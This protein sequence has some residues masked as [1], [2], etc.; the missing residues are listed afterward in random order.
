[1]PWWLLDNTVIAA[2][3]A[4]IVAL[5]CRVRRVPPVVRHALW[6]VV[7]IKL[8]APPLFP[9]PIKIPVQW[10]LLSERLAAT[11][12]ERADR[13]SGILPLQTSS[14]D[15]IGKAVLRD[16]RD[17]AGCRVDD[18]GTLQSLE[19]QPEPPVLPEARDRYSIIA[20]RAGSPIN[21][22]E[23]LN[24][25][26]DDHIA[27]V[28]APQNID[29][30][31]NA[32]DPSPPPASPGATL[33]RP[34]SAATFV[35]AGFLGATC[36]VIGV[37][38]LRLVNLRRL[39]TRARQAPGDFVSIV[40][41]LAVNVGVTAPQV[42]F[43]ADI[44][45]PLVC[46]F[47]LPVLVWPASRLASLRDN[48]LRAVI[49]H[50]LAHL[51]R[52]D[53]LVGWLELVAGCLWWW[54]PLFWYVQHQLRETAELACDAWVMALIPEG[55]RDYAR[56][57][58][59]LAELDFR[60]CRAALALGV[61]EGSKNLFERRLVMIM[62]TRVR[63]RMGIFG[64]L[65]TG[66]LA[67]A[68]LPGCTAG[69]AGDEP[70]VAAE[71]A[72]ATIDTEPADHRF[73]PVSEPP[74][75]RGP[76]LIAANQDPLD[77]VDG[78]LSSAVEDSLDDDVAEVPIEPPVALPTILPVPDDSFASDSGY[79]VGPGDTATTGKPSNDDRLKR[80]ED[81]F[82][83]L[84]NELRDAKNPTSRKSAPPAFDAQNVPSS[85]AQK[86]T[87]P[88]PSKPVKPVPAAGLGPIH[89]TKAPHRDA[90]VETVALTRA[91][92]KFPAD[93]A[94]ALKAF[95]EFLAAHLS[96]EVEVRFKDGA[97]QVTATSEDQAVIAQFIRLLQ[98]RGSAEPKPSLKRDDR[99]D[100]SATPES[101]PFGEPADDQFKPARRE[102]RREPLAPADESVPS[103]RGPRVGF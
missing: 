29:A 33:S 10:R 25:G 79:P 46:A 13:R 93:K 21:D 103:K 60:G 69:Q 84:L 35:I 87:K 86:G 85:A 8:I 43:S 80:L 66:L 40:E 11:G 2:V 53:H 28:D 102:G 23:P 17:A 6:L 94:R 96:D 95:T 18:D 30:T 1:M 3:L 55:R 90:A 57:L 63:H 78:S 4:L 16:A 54:N 72:S 24:A 49:L 74:A 76:R 98:T 64:I 38:V 101:S 100:A 48:A 51:A 7:L 89:I 77:S 42:R 14:A 61:A 34:M 62:G 73:L 71:A 37:Q 68:A 65:G 75:V 56:A 52:R 44:S 70:L 39:L 15:E 97:L 5:V 83:A 67:L 91:T 41:D 88:L 59:D 26:P 9:G 19:E 58:V 31:H 47:G 92:Y 22:A 45:T 50:E 20:P 36:V 27:A 81:R 12:G 82:D 32:A 99:D